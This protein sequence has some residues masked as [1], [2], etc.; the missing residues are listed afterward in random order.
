MRERTIRKLIRKAKR[1]KRMIEIK[2]SKRF[3]DHDGEVFKTTSQRKIEE[4]LKQL[5]SIIGKELR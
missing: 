2:E 1:M 5:E 3:W 4:Q